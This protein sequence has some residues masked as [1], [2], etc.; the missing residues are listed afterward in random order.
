[1]LVRMYAESRYPMLEGAR[2][3]VVELLHVTIAS[4]ALKYT[5]QTTVLY[6]DVGAEDWGSS[7]KYVRLPDLLPRF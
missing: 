4:E 1:M 7:S 2:P 3:V 5:G 6:L